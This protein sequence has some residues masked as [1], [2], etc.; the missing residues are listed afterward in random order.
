MAKKKVNQRSYH[1]NYAKYQTTNGKTLCYFNDFYDYNNLPKT[2]FKY[3]L[4]D[5]ALAE[6]NKNNKSKNKKKLIENLTRLGEL[7]IDDFDDGSR[8]DKEKLDSNIPAGYT[9]FG[10]FIDHDISA[11]ST[12]NAEFKIT[13]KVFSPIK[14]DDLEAEMVNNRTPEFDLDSVYGGPGN[15]FIT[16]PMF[17]DSTDSIKLK[18]GTNEASP[19]ELPDRQLESDATKPQRDLPRLGTL[20][21]T[22]ETNPANRPHT[23]AILGDMRNDENLLIAQF[24]LAFLKCHN[25]LVDDIR[26]IH[27]NMG[28]TDV[29]NAARNELTQLYQWLVIN[30]FLKQVLD[31]EVLELLLTFKEGIYEINPSVGNGAVYMPIEFSTAAYRFGHTM[32]RNQYDYNL[33][34]GRDEGNTPFLDRSTFDLLFS[35]TGTGAINNPRFN[36]TLPLNWIIQWNRFFE[37]ENQKDS[38][39]VPIEDRFTRSLDTK[40]ATFITGAHPKGMQNEDFNLLSTEQQTQARASAGSAAM[41][42]SIMKRLATRNLLRGYLFNMPSGQKMIL[43][44][45]SLNRRKLQLEIL[46]EQDILQNASDELKGLIKDAGYEKDTPLWY[47]ILKEAE[48]Q[49]NGNSLGHLG[50]WIVGQTIVGLIKN[51]TGISVIRDNWSPSQSIIPQLRNTK[52]IMDLLIYAGV[53]PNRT[54]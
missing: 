32:V 2:D 44:I 26:A 47:Y 43:A 19:G 27:P 38:A 50:S 34:F 18:I 10:Q 8:I 52:N 25:K 42:N 1:G 45:N 24:H 4:K 6:F 17:Y 7:M 3:F 9:Y 28:N 53:A 16:F 14:P 49:S 12:P 11:G 51:G 13:E 15:A 54:V 40:L 5:L 35:F 30:D 33:N 20:A 22:P 31:E 48:I 23:A 46:S 36:N 37:T 39:G 29:F 41:F 21:D